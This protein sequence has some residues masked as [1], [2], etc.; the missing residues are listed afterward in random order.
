VG[1]DSQAWYVQHPFTPEYGGFYEPAVAYDS[2]SGW[3]NTQTATINSISPSASLTP[4]P[5]V[6]E[7]SWFIVVLFL[8]VFN[9]TT[10]LTM[11]KRFVK[12]G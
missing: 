10:L 8:S 6:P 9:A 7:F 2:D 12:N 11:K 4:T 1:H 3:S 5:T